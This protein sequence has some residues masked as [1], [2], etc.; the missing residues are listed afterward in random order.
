[1]IDLET[2]MMELGRK[3]QINIHNT[4]SLIRT[5]QVSLRDLSDGRSLHGQL[6]NI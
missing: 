6:T 4:R 1:M 5:H 3:T 2:E